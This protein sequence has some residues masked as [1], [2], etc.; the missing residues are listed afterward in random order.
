MGRIGEAPASCSWAE[1]EG[2]WRCTHARPHAPHV[3]SDHP[4]TCSADRARPSEIV[5][6]VLHPGRRRRFREESHRRA[7]DLTSLYGLGSSLDSSQLCC[8]SG[9][10]RILLHLLSCTLDRP[11][12]QVLRCVREDLQRPEL[13][14][15][16]TSATQASSR[17]SHARTLEQLLST[18]RHSSRPLVLPPNRPFR[19]GKPNAMFCAAITIDL[20]FWY[21]S[22]R[23]RSKCTHRKYSAAAQRSCYVH[24]AGVV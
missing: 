15:L 10:S 21:S 22:R 19:P 23:R 18:P 3:A 20:C 2:S 17:S 7:R 6:A 1:R 16:Q 11:A 14:C 12:I 4:E 5:A 8:Q 24:H 9:Q 13:H